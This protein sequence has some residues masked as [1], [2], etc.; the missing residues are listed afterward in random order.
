MRVCVLSS[1]GDVSWVVEFRSGDW[2]SGRV[3]VLLERYGVNLC[4]VSAPWYSSELFRTGPVIYLRMHGEEALY[5]STYTDEDLGIWASRLSNS[6]LSWPGRIG[7]ETEE[8]FVFLNNT[9]G[10]AVG[11]AVTLR[12]FLDD[13]RSVS[14]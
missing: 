3:F 9:D 14:R 5:S 1:Y 7:P 6:S 2:F 11:N 10:D 13:L 4:S 8:V 12:R